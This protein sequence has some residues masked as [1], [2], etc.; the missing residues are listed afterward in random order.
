MPVVQ[1]VFNW[2][3]SSA[4]GLGSWAWDATLVPMWQYFVK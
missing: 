2:A 3:V 1:N 4:Q